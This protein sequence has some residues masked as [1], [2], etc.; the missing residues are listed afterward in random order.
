MGWEV[1]VRQYFG[2]EFGRRG[3]II[4]AHLTQLMKFSPI[5]DRRMRTNL[6]DGMNEKSNEEIF[7][8]ERIFFFF[9]KKNCSV[10]LPF[11]F[12]FLAMLPPPSRFS[13]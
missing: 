10:V 5:S 13:P 9:L 7:R 6:F 8:W 4:D 12:L 1:N 2:Y 11:T 3:R